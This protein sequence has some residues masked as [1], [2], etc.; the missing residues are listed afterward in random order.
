MHTKEKGCTQKNNIVEVKK[1]RN[2]LF[3]IKDWNVKDV[4][5]SGMNLSI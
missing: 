4:V 1:W 5:E 2:K 3:C